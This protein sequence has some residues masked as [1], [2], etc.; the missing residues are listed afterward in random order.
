MSAQDL[1]AAFTIAQAAPGPNLL[2][3]TLIGLQAAGLLGALAATLGI[4]LPPALIALAAL[5]MS[6]NRALAGFGRIVKGGLRPISVGLM[7]ATGWALAR[8]ADTNWQELLLTLITVAVVLRTNINP[9]WL[10]SAGAL[11]GIVNGAL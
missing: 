1:V 6:R 10:I 5:R 2:Y 11:V 9:L 7:L 4:V 8:A 3:F